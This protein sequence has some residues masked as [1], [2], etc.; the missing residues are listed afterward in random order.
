MR[1]SDILSL[2]LKPVI[3]N[4]VNQRTQNRATDSETFELD[5]N[6]MRD[7]RRLGSVPRQ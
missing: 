4:A 6:H 5:G 1:F 3:E 2:K 7:L